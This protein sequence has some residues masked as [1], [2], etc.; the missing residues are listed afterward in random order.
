[1]KI[2]EGVHRCQKFGKHFIILDTLSNLTFR[3]PFTSYIQPN[4]PINQFF[5]HPVYISFERLR[6]SLV[7][8]PCGTV[9]FRGYPGT[10]YRP[11]HREDVSGLVSGPA[12]RGRRR[13]RRRRIMNRCGLAP[14][15]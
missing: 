12:I 5:H 3:G 7:S 8:V 14:T 11:G 10:S 6:S 13:R 1:M 15:C 2:T 9:A 4:L